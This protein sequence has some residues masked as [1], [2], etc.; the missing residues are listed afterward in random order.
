MHACMQLRRYGPKARNVVDVYLPA[1]ASNVN[2]AAPV[3]LFC[4]GGV[5]A[6]GKAARGYYPRT[7]QRSKFAQHPSQCTPA[8]WAVA[9]RLS[10]TLHMRRRRQ[11]ELCAHGGAISGRGRADAGHALQVRDA[12]RS[13][14][15]CGCLPSCVTMAFPVSRFRPTPGIRARTDAGFVQCSLYPEALVPA[16]VDETSAALSWTLD[17]AASLGGDPDRVCALRFL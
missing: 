14:L 1:A 12:E 8:A 17:N 15:A 6:A 16:M 9:P 10:Q 13:C 5:W 7:Y 3:A 2:G 4:H 11:V